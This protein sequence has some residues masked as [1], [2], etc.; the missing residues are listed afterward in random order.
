LKQPKTYCISATAFIA[1]LALL[2][3][4]SCAGKKPQQLSLVAS[5]ENMQLKT[6]E[7]L[8]QLL[9]SN[10]S[11]LE[12]KQPALTALV[13]QNGDYQTLWS[14]N[15][16]WKASA[17]TLF[18][19]I[20]DAKL[21]GL[22]PEDYHQPSLQAFRELFLTDSLGRNEKADPLL[23]S[24]AD[25]SLTDA[26]MQLVKDVKF[27]HLPNDSI[28]LN[29]DSIFTNEFYVQAAALADHPDSISSFIHSLEP[30][31]WGYTALKAGIRQFLRNAEF[32][33]LT[34]VPTA[35]KDSLAF[36]L[37]LKR[38]LFEGGYIN[39]D[40]TAMDSAMLSEAVKKFQ[41]E[42]HLVVD[43]KAGEG[44]VR[45]LNLSDREKFIR[46]A[47]S[48][49]KYKKLPPSMPP[50]YIWVNA[51]ANTMVVVDN[52]SF[53]INSKV[54][55]G[56]VTTKT[57]L[58]NG[59][60]SAI[61]TYPQWVPPPAIIQKEILPAVKKNPGYL[62]KKGFT[63][64]DKDGEEVDPFT[65]E[66]NK[67][68]KTIPYKVVQGSGDANA[69]G[70]IKF[71]FDNKYSVYLHDTNQRY[72]FA[73]AMRNLSHGCVRV[74]EW[75]SLVSYMLRNDS[76]AAGRGYAMADSVKKWL[77]NKEKHQVAIKSRL[78]VFIR[79]FTCEGKDGQVL[80][81]DDVYGSDKLI[82]EKYFA[83]K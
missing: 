48:M 34:Y 16:N 72:L 83:S 66:W 70:I 21:M 74:Q 64:F 39:S 82:R 60:I 69:L 75:Q 36:R 79:Y 6:R 63:L 44:T 26:F 71:Y 27:G 41:K 9:Q 22:F 78:P 54:I 20:S 59:A 35:G 10:D 55:T 8:K 11:S 57:P 28:S 33:D 15:E 56:K 5:A 31:H 62:A 23:W 47:I 13:Y 45:M 58:L 37:A 24:K 1:I 43:G 40:S 65:V 30:T 17:D 7:H 29:K 67:Y 25:I 81:Y 80:F 77:K 19:I 46:I 76:L 50:R 38:R 51:S 14:G 42:K 52:G 49:D 18:R 32:R 61:I 53:K 12:L 68:T 2:F 4:S 73:N 3:T